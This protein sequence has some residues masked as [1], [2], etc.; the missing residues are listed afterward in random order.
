MLFSWIVLG[1]FIGWL[2]GILTDSEDGYILNLFF[3][4]LGAIIGGII[5][6]WFSSGEFILFPYYEVFSWRS[7][8]FAFVGSIIFISLLTAIRNLIKN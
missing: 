4:V 6:Y 7:I 8:W 1:L 3:C 2:A 5:E